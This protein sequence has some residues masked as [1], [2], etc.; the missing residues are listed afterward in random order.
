M[1]SLVFVLSRY[2]CIKLETILLFLL[3]DLALASCRFVQAF[4]SR[5]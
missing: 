3:D 5:V 2:T 1:V 4:S